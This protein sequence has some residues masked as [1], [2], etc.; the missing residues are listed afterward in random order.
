M[1]LLTDTEQ[2]KLLQELYDTAGKISEKFERILRKYGLDRI[3]AKT[4]DEVEVLRKEVGKQRAQGRG[5]WQA[6]WSGVGTI[7]QKGDELFKD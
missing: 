4:L 1:T 6:F 3:P 2:K 5:L 7:K